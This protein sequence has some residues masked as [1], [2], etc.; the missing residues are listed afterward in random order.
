MLCLVDDSRDDWFRRNRAIISQPSAL[1]Q[2]SIG[3]AIAN[4]A[5]PP[6]GRFIDVGGANGHI[7]AA[8]KRDY[9]DWEGVVVDVSE[10]ACRDGKLRFPNLDFFPMDISNPLGVTFLGKFDLV[11]VAG[12]F[13]MIPRSNLAFA[14][15]NLDS[16]VDG[17]AGKIMI[18]DFATAVP[19]FS[20]SKHGKHQ[21]IYKQNY[22]S[23]FEA[24]GHYLMIFSEVVKVQPEKTFDEKSFFDLLRTTQVLQKSANDDFYQPTL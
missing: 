19:S 7:A 21:K 3:N 22:G 8:L 24:L 18:R 1:D 13:P 6:T 2:T 10:E 15:A 5:L 20:V 11:I 17:N 16:L 12:V 23:I 14:V 9:P 4:L